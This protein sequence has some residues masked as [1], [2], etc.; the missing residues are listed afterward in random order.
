MF[1]TVD[2]IGHSLLTDA[3]Q[4]MLKKNI[5]QQLHAQAILAWLIW[6]N[7]TLNRAVNVCFIMMRSVDCYLE[8]TN[9]PSS[10]SHQP[11]EG[12]LLYLILEL[13]YVDVKKIKMLSIKHHDKVFSKKS[14][15]QCKML[16]VGH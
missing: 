6:R 11:M 2:I 5:H 8:T 4:Q 16:F 14:Q 10:E 15:T 13:Q 12:G 7:K 1:I 3:F 9:P